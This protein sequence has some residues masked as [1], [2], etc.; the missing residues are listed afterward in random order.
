MR[1]PPT[2]PPNFSLNKSFCLLMFTFL[3]F[4]QD[5]SLKATLVKSQFFSDSVLFGSSVPGRTFPGCH[6][7]CQRESTQSENLLWSHL[8]DKEGYEGDL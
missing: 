3:P 7:P 1:A 8:S 2:G 6:V 4:D 5:F